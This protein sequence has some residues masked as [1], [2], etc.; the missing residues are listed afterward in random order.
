[1]RFRV[2][3]TLLTL[4]MSH[5]IFFNS[6]ASQQFPDDSDPSQRPHHPT[7]KTYRKKI[8][9]AQ[10]SKIKSFQ[11]VWQQR[12][13]LL[14]QILPY[15][16]LVNIADNCPDEMM[17]PICK[18]WT[19]VRDLSNVR[20]NYL[21]KPWRREE[22]EALTTLP[23]IKHV[24]LSLNKLPLIESG[25]LPLPHGLRS[26]TLDE[27]A[28]RDADMKSLCQHLTALEK[29]KIVHC[30]QLTQQWH[31]ALEGMTQL[32]HIHFKNAHWVTDA[33]AI[34]IGHLT[35]LRTLSLPWCTRYS[36]QAALQ[37]IEPLKDLET[38]DLYLATPSPKSILRVSQGKPLVSLNLAGKDFFTQDNLH[39]LANFS[40]LRHLAISQ[41]HAVDQ[42][43]KPL[44]T[45]L[46]KLEGF[47]LFGINLTQEIYTTLLPYLTHLKHFEVRVR[48][49]DKQK[50]K[51]SLLLHQLK[52]LTLRNIDFTERHLQNYPFSRATNLTEL[53]LARAHAPK[54]L[55]EQIGT[56]TQL[57]SLICPSFT[58]FDERHFEVLSQLTA[59]EK[60]VIPHRNI[61]FENAAKFLT[62]LSRLKELD[63]SESADLAAHIAELPMM[64]QVTSL[65]LKMTQGSTITPDFTKLSALS[66]LTLEGDRELSFEEYH[67]LSQ[68]PRLRL[69][70]YSSDHVRLKLAQKKWPFIVKKKTLP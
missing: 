17:F 38:L 23:R 65:C 40:G 42:R 58:S 31:E 60:L 34:S 19:Q 47:T 7:R 27:M 69:V 25:A 24:A 50:K 9:Q 64:S 10:H 36:P 48:Q 52:T 26:L 61:S 29:L 51:K 44:L 54:L 21:Y 67:I 8:P 49:N 12:E 1:M 70:F 63:I 68:L 20:S 2:L 13:S 46:E 22:I 6:F 35:P 53:D 16:I 18:K 30:K 41:S 28:L 3:P 45:T 11:G 5:L 66:H 14:F 57:K 62:A 33:F 37:M 15:E 55:L 43:V 59:L 56:L 4:V 32:R 39:L